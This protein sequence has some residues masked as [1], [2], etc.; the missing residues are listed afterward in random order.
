MEYERIKK[1]KEKELALS[2]STPFFKQKTLFERVKY[3]FVFDSFTEAKHTAA[4]LS[5]QKLALPVGFE[6]YDKKKWEEIFIPPQSKADLKLPSNFAKIDVNSMDDLGKTVFAGFKTLNKI[7]SIVY[8]TAFNTNNNL[9]ICAPTGAGKTNI[10]ML[11]ILNELRKYYNY[12]S[13]QFDSYN[14][15]IIYIA[16]MKALAAEMVSNFSKRLDPL[17]IK[18]KEL[19][20][21][22]Q[23][24][25]AQIVETHLIVTTP[26][27][28]DIVTRKPKSDIVLMELVKLLI[29]DEVHLLQS[30]R[31]P[32][33]EALVARTIR[34][35]ES[36]QTMIRIIGLSA[37]LPNY[38][39]VANFL[40]VNL[41][42]GLFFFDDRFRPVPLYQNFISVRATQAS[43]QLLD[44]D[45]I[46]FEKVQNFVSKNQ[47]CMI[48]VHSRSSTFRTA[49]SLK[50]LAQQKGIV[51]IFK[52]T[53]VLG[54]VLERPQNRE[55]RELLPYGFAI[56]HAGMTRF[57]RS[58]VEKLFKEGKVKVLVCTA[59][60]AW[61]I[62]LPAHAVIIRGTEI[63]DPA[64]G[65]YVDLS[66]LDVM[67]IFGR[68]GRPQFDK[69]GHGMIITTSD[70]F[71][72]YL[73]LH[74]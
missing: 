45:E 8:Q 26:E 37:T 30:D 54:K 53:D 28:W 5:G 60:L 7:Q 68:A 2:M 31:G 14:F 58:F 70:K 39:D 20:G 10:A 21:D 59:T 24:T 32:V 48:F 62:N 43:Q 57:D 15:K 72:F 74:L 4:Y 33:L 22:M 23:L 38:I 27:K 47:Q 19:T 16:P 29:I 67:Q 12:E 65:S 61:G 63:Y 69:E 36:T 17:G 55:L 46:C 42:E 25:K 66:L 56:H 1:E 41:K 51:D 11:G 71:V 13:K 64:H 52:P 44:M 35:V 6:R 3:P 34:H 49:F 18:V 40:Q 9:L 50:Q 73:S